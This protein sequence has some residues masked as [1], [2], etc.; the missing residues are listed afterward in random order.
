LNVFN[1]TM[2][3]SLQPRADG[4]AVRGASSVRGVVGWTALVVVGVNVPLGMG[5]MAVEAAG[6]R[7]DGLGFVL[8]LAAFVAA[9]PTLVLGFPLGLLTAWS[10]RSVPHERTHVAA[11]ALVGAATATA[12]AVVPDLWGAPDTASPP[13]GAVLWYALEGALGAGAG[14]WAAGAVRRRRAAR[15]RAPH[16]VGVAA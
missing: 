5:L 7:L 13:P 2:N 10:L 4:P 15:A 16:D 1:S 12:I 6:T 3:P 9:L 14:R 8:V 11:F